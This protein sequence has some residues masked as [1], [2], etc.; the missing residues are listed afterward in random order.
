[1]QSLRSR[2]A[3]RAGAHHFSSRA[4]RGVD[5]TCGISCPG[6]QARGF[7]PPPPSGREHK[8]PAFAPLSCA[9]RIVDARGR[10]PRDT[11]AANKGKK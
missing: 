7:Q 10:E 3:V 9:G 6:V 2:V 8:I 5:G 4:S 11:N 1:M